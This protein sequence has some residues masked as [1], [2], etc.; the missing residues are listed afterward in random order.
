MAGVSRRFAAALAAG[1]STAVMIALVATEVA[2]SAW[3][4]YGI[5]EPARAYTLVMLIARLGVS[6]LATVV[7]ACVA[8]TVARD[9]GRAACWLGGL[10]L[11]A[12]LPLHLYWRWADYPA[13]YHFAYLSSLVPFA[14]LTGRALSR[15]DVRATAPR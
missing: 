14:A 10:V 11:A 1:F 7:A 8:T 3:P 13:W 5:A 2:R 9:G 4:A 15:R 12:S 6:L